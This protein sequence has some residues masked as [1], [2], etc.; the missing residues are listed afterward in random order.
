MNK[1]AGTL[2]AV[3]V[4][5]FIGIS[6]AGNDTDNFDIEVSV[7]AYCETYGADDHTISYNPFS[8][9]SVQSLG[10]FS[11]GCVKGTYFTLTGYSHNNPAG[12][13]GILLPSGSDSASTDYLTYTV[14]ASVFYV[15][16]GVSGYDSNIFESSYTGTLSLTAPTMSPPTVSFAVIGMNSGQNVAPDTYSDTVTIVIS[17]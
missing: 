10:Y 17:Y 6:N 4:A 16:Y 2:V 8:P 13:Y 14:S 3:F 11:F 12:N 15:S 1:I 7:S 5:G 9:S